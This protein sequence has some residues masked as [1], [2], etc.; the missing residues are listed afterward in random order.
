MPVLLI[1]RFR[2]VVADR[3]AH[4][5]ACVDR[6]RPA[7]QPVM[8]GAVKD[9]GDAH[10][11]AGRRHFDYGKQCVIIHDA[12]GQQGFVD[13]AM[14]QVK[15][16]GVVQPAPGTHG[17]E[18]P[19]VFMIPK[20]MNWRGYVNSRLASVRNG[21]RRVRFLRVVLRCGSARQAAAVRIAGRLLRASGS[22]RG[23]KQQDSRRNTPWWN[24]D[25]RT[26]RPFSFR[27]AAFRKS[28]TARGLRSSE[29]QIV[30]KARKVVKRE[31]S[32]RRNFCFHEVQCGPHSEFF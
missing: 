31:A 29:A 23:K 12:V 26:G 1:R 22:N 5:D 4:R 20:A 30:G 17:S 25:L 16:G 18:Q 24:S 9:V 32:R 8:P 7:L 28:G 11:G 19:K 6:G 14:S 10:R 27:A 2:I 21:E 15:R 13:S 3:S